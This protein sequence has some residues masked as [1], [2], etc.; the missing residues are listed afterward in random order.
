[1]VKERGTYY[2]VDPIECRLISDEIVKRPRED[3]PVA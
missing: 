2:P 1:M 3:F